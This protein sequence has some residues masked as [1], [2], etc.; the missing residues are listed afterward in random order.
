MDNS[1]TTADAAV[2]LGLKLRTVQAH[3]KRGNLS[4]VWNDYARRY[5]IEPDEIER[6][7]R[8][9]RKP[10]FPWLHDGSKP[11]KASME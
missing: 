2:A 4:A 10:G 11:K 7:K 5:E 3:I 6:F 9:N 8:E 1:L